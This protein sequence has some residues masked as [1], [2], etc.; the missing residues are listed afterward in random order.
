M[1]FTKLGW[2]PIDDIIRTR[3]LISPLIFPIMLTMSRMAMIT[4]RE[5]QEEYL[6]TPKGK[7]HSGLRTFHSS[8]TCLWNKT[9]PSLRDTLSQKRF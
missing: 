6:I 3:K 1:W 7:K 2:L 9:E 8:A 5:P 4:T